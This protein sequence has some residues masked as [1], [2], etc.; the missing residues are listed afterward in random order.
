VP[1]R[2]ICARVAV[3]AM[4]GAL[5]LSGCGERPSASRQ[6]NILLVVWDTVRAD[7]LG[8]YGYR[9]ATT[10]RLERWVDEARVFEDCVS[11][12]P[13]TVPS[14]AS[15]FTGLL[16]SDHGAGFEHAW[17]DD[18]HDTLAE[19]LR[20]AG[21]QTFLWSANPHVSAVENFTQGFEVAEHP[22]DADQRERA[23]AI[24]RQKLVGDRS[25]E[26]GGVV[27]RGQAGEWAIKAA[28]ELAQERLENWIDAREAERP[29]FAFLNYM[30]AHRPLVPPRRFRERVMTPERVE[31]SYHV[32]RSWLAIWSYSF[33]LR[34]YSDEEL[35]VMSGTYDAAI[36]E[37]DALLDGVLAALR[38]RGLLDD[39]V[40]VLVSDHGEMLGEHHMLDHQYALYRPLLQVPLVI[41]Y[42]RRFAPGRESAPAM[43]L[44]LFP[45][46]LE[47]AG[48]EPPT[49]AHAHSL[50][51][52]PA[53]RVRIAEY[54]SAFRD[55]FPAVRRA[56]P[57]WDPT[58]WERALRAIHEDPWKL[59]W[60][61]DGR[62]ELYDRERDPGESDDLSASR[63]DEVARLEKRLEG[64]LSATPRQPQQTAP[65]VSEEHRKMLEALG[66]AEPSPDPSTPEEP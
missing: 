62:H 47:L 64:K 26:L 52:L 56:F 24:V 57:D 43:S 32:D 60:G 13:W 12:S 63:A 23:L 29:F 42:P 2:H 22:W 30:E 21:Y 51:A 1:L 27:R 65:A 19:Q 3:V 39:T 38:T 55:A 53:E 44:D 5:L 45:T 18:Q 20:T 31:H 41:R 54:P 14:H 10:P 35:A 36:A 34:E 15:I 33:G 66:Y 28:G 11:P 58:P 50:L 40:V 8:P 59:I 6:P 61:S 4:L 37:L 46:L 25:S 9:N 48:L 7:R 17:L 49:R 16:P